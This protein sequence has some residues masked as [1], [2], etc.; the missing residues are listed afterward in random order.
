MKLETRGPGWTN[1]SPRHAGQ[2][3]LLVEDESFVRDVTREVL[4]HAGYQVIESSNAKDALQLASE[5]AG[6]IDLL[7]TDLVMPGMSGAELAQ[8]L[9]HAKPGLATIF[10]S[11]YAETD[12]AQTMKSASAIHIQKPF[13]VDA[14]LAQVAQALR[15]DSGGVP[16]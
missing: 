9:R 2:V 11:G 3:I 4:V 6:S 15:P 8:C 14:L 5:H 12:A 1:N 7:L 10:M 13:T 16:A